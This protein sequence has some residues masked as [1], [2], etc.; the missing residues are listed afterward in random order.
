MARGQWVRVIQEEGEGRTPLLSSPGL[1]LWVRWE[2]LKALSGRVTC[3]NL[4]FSRTTLAN[5]ARWRQGDQLG[6]NVVVQVRG[7]GGLGHG[8]WWRWWEGNRCF[9]RS[10]KI[11]WR[12]GMWD[13]R[14]RS[15]GWLQGLQPE[16]LEG[17]L[18]F[19]E[20]GRLWEE[21]A[22]WAWAAQ[23]GFGHIWRCLLVFQEI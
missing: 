12:D 19:I 14:E 21:L 17:A 20:T 4:D 9:L 1:L 2:S 13:V 3:F 11:C 18:P 15:Q 6:A 22:N 5:C 16:H 10:D 8:G 23:F 7:D